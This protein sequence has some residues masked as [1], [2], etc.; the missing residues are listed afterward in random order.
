MSNNFQISNE[1]NN[2]QSKMKKKNK[3]K[4]KRKRPQRRTWP[5]SVSFSGYFSFVEAAVELEGTRGA[6]WGY[7]DAEVGEGTRRK[8]GHSGRRRG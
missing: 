8:V 7:R 1:L 5:C 4:E 2:Y 3:E 6:E